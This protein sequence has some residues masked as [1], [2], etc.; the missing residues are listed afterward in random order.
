[1][2]SEKFLIESGLYDKISIEYE[3]FE[4]LICLLSGKQKIDLYCNKCK[5][6]RIF[7]ARSNKIKVSPK[8]ES[9][10]NIFED[11]GNQEEQEAIDNAIKKSEERKELERFERFLRDNALTVL[12]Y[13]CSRDSNHRVTFI[14]LIE[15]HDIRKIGQYPSYADID[16]PQGDIYRKELGNKYYRELKRA[17][18]L[19]SCNVGIG[20]F[21]YLRRILEKLLMDA[22]EVAIKDGA[23]T[24]DDFDYIV[25]DDKKHPR[26]VEDKIKLL[27]DYLPKILTEN[28]NVYGVIS[29]GIHEL[30]EDECLK[31]FPVV[32][33]I[34]KMCLTEVIELKRKKK[35]ADEL[36]SMLS[37]IATE[38]KKK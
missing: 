19:Y 32:E 37:S 6:K 18:G 2:D 5:E 24:R 17:V 11:Y 22:M 3:D 29:K 14:L 28:K 34:I 23:I 15:E 26:R 25:D 12:D 8:E 4:D 20:S 30:E 33:K 21:V 1:M 36:N 35:E 31:Y 38:I 10:R 27:S 16:I 7:S 9:I 13:E